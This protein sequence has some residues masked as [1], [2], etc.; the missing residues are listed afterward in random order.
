MQKVVKKYLDAAD[1]EQQILDFAITY[2]AQRGLSF[3][4][5]ELADALGV[6]QPL[7]YRYFK[8][9]DEL[10]KKIYDEVYLKRWDQ[11]WNAQLSD[12][13]IPI[14]D[15][16]I[17]YLKAYTLAILDE[18]WI[19]IFIASALEDPQISKRYLGLLHETTFPLIYR[20]IAAEA[21]VTPPTGAAADELAVEIVWGFHCSFFYFG[22]RKYIYRNRIPEKLDPVIEARVDV[23]V[24]GLSESMRRMGTYV[25]KMEGS[26]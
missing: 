22:V 5:R 15:R 2:V 20:E 4:T 16:L 9:R 10:L 1:R 14:R 25:S 23:F 3:T 18:R 11:N 6:S 24:T 17:R 13:S 7:L 12:R 26:K 19:R 8:N 21:G